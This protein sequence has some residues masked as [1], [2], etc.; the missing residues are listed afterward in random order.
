MATERT[1]AQHHRRALPPVLRPRLGHRH[2]RRHQHPRGR[3]RLH[4][5]E[6]RAEGAPRP[7]K[8]STCST[9]RASVLA[10]PSRAGLKLS[11]CSP[12]FFNAYR[13]RDAGAVIHSHGIVR[14]ARHAAREGDEFECTEIEMI[15]G[16]AGHG[17]YD[18]LVV[19]IIENTAHE[20]DLAGPHGGGD[21]RLSEV[22]ARCSCAATACTSGAA[23]GCTRRRRPSATTTCSRPR[24]ACAQLGLDAAAPN[25]SR[26]GVA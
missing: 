1:P 11:E 19:P 13:L 6:R 9:S 20:C 7:R 24:C 4:G 16:I 14:D 15:K 5:A 23:T 2:G 12:L 3:P 17:Y 18:R 22:A 8:T 10:G 25:R 26:P 21:R